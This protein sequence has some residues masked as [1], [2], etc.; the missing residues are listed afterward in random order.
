MEPNKNKIGRN[1]TVADD[2]DET[3]RPIAT[4]RI[5]Q[6]GSKPHTY[7]YIWGT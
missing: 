7:L 5:L 6:T 1:T 2:I 4:I 3:I